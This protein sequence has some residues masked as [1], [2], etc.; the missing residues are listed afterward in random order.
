MND[1]RF[2]PNESHGGNLLISTS[3]D[4]HFK[5]FDTRDNKAIVS[6]KA[7]EESLC[8]GSFNPIFEHLFAVA[9]DSSGEI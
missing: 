9:G 6:C 8:V 7:A 5:I 3:D 4:A 1:V 2:S